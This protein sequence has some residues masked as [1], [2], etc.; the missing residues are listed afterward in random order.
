MTSIFLQNRLTSNVWIAKD[1]LYLSSMLALQKI[2]FNTPNE[3]PRSY[4]REKW[5]ISNLFFLSFHP[6]FV[7]PSVYIPSP[8]WDEPGVYTSSYTNK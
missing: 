4:K 6:A 3:N 1:Y 7:S 5:E 2:K 8:Y